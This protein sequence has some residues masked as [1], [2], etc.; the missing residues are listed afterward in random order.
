MELILLVA[1]L[2]NSL[3]I[4]ISLCTCSY[5]SGVCHRVFT[6]NIEV[7][8][9]FYDRKRLGR[10]LQSQ[11]DYGNM[12]RTVADLMSTD[13]NKS[14]VSVWLWEHKLVHACSHISWMDN[15]SSLSV[16]WPWTVWRKR[17][18]EVLIRS[19]S[20]FNYFVVDLFVILFEITFHTCLL[21][22]WL[23]ASGISG[24]YTHK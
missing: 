13:S 7:T 14:A 18:F 17:R 3:T 19:D 11:R 20:Y 23:V 16:T 2:F 24:I 1:N 9:V 8:E 15:S 21:F 6:G 4:F 12:E 5:I 22:R 10:T